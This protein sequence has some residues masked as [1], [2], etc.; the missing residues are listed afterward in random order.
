MSCTKEPLQSET[1]VSD[2]SAVR[3]RAQLSQTR[4]TESS[5]ESG[6][7]ISI[8][9]SNDYSGTLYSY[10]YADNSEYHYYSGE[11][12]PATSEDV[13]SYPDSY[14]SLYFYAVWPYSSSYS[15]STLNF[16]VKQDQTTA[17]D[18]ASSNLMIAKT[19][20]TREETVDL[21]F[22]HLMCKV[23]INIKSDNFPAGE[24]L[25]MFNNVYTDVTL[26]LNDGTVSTTGSQTFVIGSKNGTNSFKVLLP[27]QTIP[28]GT[29]FLVFS[30]GED[31]WQ[32]KP[33]RALVLASGVEYEYT[34]TI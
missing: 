15:G 20:A 26:N 17:S 13:I 21:N 24:W 4:A 16:S 30:I 3:F 28:S 29:Q 10:N 34:L 19:D 6:D 5:F 2:D 11:F 33:S 25:S 31:T 22:D 8:F 27:P 1:G 18:Y 23:I 12:S 7:A 32:W 9:A 14:T